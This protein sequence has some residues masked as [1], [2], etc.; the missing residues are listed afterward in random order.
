MQLL[1][2]DWIVDGLDRVRLKGIA[3]W[4]ERDHALRASPLTRPSGATT[5]AELVG[6]LAQAGR[7]YTEPQK[8]ELWYLPSAGAIERLAEG[9]QWPE[10]VQKRHAE[11]VRPVTGALFHLPLESRAE[12]ITVFITDWSPFPAACAIAVHRHHP[13]V[14]GRSFASLPAPTGEYVRHPLTGDLLPVWV[15]E[16]VRPDFGTGAVVVNP[17]HDQTDLRFARAVGLPIR[18]GLRPLDGDGRPVAWP[19]PPVLKSGIAVRTGEWGGLPAAEAAAAYIERLMA[20]GYA[21]VHRDRQIGRRLLGRLTPDPA[22]QLGLCPACGL[23]G[24]L[25]DGHCACGESWA[26]VRLEGGDLLSAL[27]ALQPDLPF[28]LIAPAGSVKE[29]LLTARLLWWDLYGQA[30]AP[31]ELLLVNKVQGSL[32]ALEPEL[33]PLALLVGAPPAEPVIA[34]QALFDQIRKAWR[35]DQELQGAPVST[36][37]GTKVATQVK[38]ALAERNPARA[39]ALLLPWQKAIHA[40]G[41]PVPLEYRELAAQLF[42]RS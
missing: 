2:W 11:A 1:A 21:E 16:W 13:L 34:K 36:E 24:S 25:T 10:G 32:D 17:A 8:E 23:I 6:R 35:I 40:G 37:S 29:A 30:F 26:P 22:G 28:T 31:A 41:Q 3:A 42:S 27:A 7:L 5:P 9:T 18:F 4:L 39:F 12:R 20:D 15:A 14:R 19:E 38:A 33:V